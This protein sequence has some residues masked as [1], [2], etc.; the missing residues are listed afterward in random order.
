MRSRQ[1]EQAL[2][3]ADAAVAR[4]G[5]LYQ[6]HLNRA[7]VLVYLGRHEEALESLESAAR[8]NSRSPEPFAML[9][10]QQARLGRLEQAESNYRNAL[11]VAPDFFPAYLGLARLYMSK[12]QQEEAERAVQKA[13]ELAPGHPAVANAAKQLENR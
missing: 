4:A 5:E 3:F 11:T 12:G 2:E 1:P 6:T 8:L 10:D 7:R 9:A 13:A